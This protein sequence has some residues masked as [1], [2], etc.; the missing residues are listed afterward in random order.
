MD[1]W[2]AT[3][4]KIDFDL[5]PDYKAMQI[6][7]KANGEHWLGYLHDD[8]GINISEKN[9]SYCEL[10]ALFSLWKNSN[11]D[12]KGLCH[13]RRFLLPDASVGIGVQRERRIPK[14]EIKNTA[15]NRKEAESF[16]RNYDMIIP[17]PN[18][19]FAFKVK[20][21]RLQ[22]CFQNDLDILRETIAQE[23]SEYLEAYD[24]VMDQHVLSAC[25]M[26]I[27]KRE[28][29]DNYCS[30]LFTVLA[31]VEQK[32]NI[33][34]YDTQHKRIYGYFS[35]HLLSVFIRK[36]NLKCKYVTRALVAEYWVN[37]SSGIKGLVKKSYPYQII[38]KNR[39]SF[40]MI[41]CYKH[42]RKKK[43]E[44]YLFL[45]QYLADREAEAAAS[46]K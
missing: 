9:E 14:S 28:I 18:G 35:E 25:N 41:W 33:E 13:Y 11:A 26:L 15:I 31:E 21:E 2:V 4:K 29:F 16:L 36:H 34:S 39:P 6:N 45:K 22:Y 7:C 24:W 38:I 43:Y 17:I 3:H 19:P 1:I 12:I 40:I 30:W 46:G 23:F 37:P 44:N 10:T 27:A 42:F 5:P 8:D 32:C 20:E